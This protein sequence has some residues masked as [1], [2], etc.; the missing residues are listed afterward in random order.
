MIREPD[1]DDPL[2]VNIPNSEGAGAVEGF[3]ISSDHFL[4]LLKVKKV[5]IGSPEN[6]KLWLI[7]KII[8]MMKPSGRSQ[9]YCMNLR[10]CSIT[11]FQR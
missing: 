2:E 5:N 9:T 4:N 1:D 11:N 10:I 3:G 8:A 6:Q 7:S